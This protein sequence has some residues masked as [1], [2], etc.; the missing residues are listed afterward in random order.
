MGN[1]EN[2]LGLIS[3]IVQASGIMEY[4]IGYSQGPEGPF[5]AAVLDAVHAYQYL[6]DR[7]Y[8]APR[9]GLL[10]ISAGGC[11]VLSALMAAREL[12]LMLPAVGICVSPWADLVVACQNA[13][14]KGDDLMNL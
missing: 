3:R 12:G 7:G 1:V 13:I 6:L 14:R 5:P 9:V 2:D 8:R 11:L 4:G 10:G